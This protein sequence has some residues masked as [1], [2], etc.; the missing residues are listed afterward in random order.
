MRNCKDGSATRRQF[1]LGSLAHF[2]LSIAGRSA[3]GPAKVSVVA[4]AVF[5]SIS[6]SAIVIAVAFNARAQRAKGRIIL[7]RAETAA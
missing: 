3:G 7:K 5:G 1:L 6:G 2:P 4:S